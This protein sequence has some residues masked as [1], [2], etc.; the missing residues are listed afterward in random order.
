MSARAPSSRLARR[1]AARTFDAHEVG[2]LRRAPFVQLA[3]ERAVD[4][5]DMDAVDPCDAPAS[6]RRENFIALRRGIR[7]Q[8]AAIASTDSSRFDRWRVL[9][10]SSMMKHECRGMH[11]QRREIGRLR[12]DEVVGAQALLDQR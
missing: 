5:A 9:P 7:S 6:A 8:A 1:I 4:D 12:V 10:V 2:D 11:G 3:A